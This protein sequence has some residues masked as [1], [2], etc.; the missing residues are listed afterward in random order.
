MSDHPAAGP[1]VR[2]TVI[3]PGWSAAV[4]KSMLG[5]R[6]FRSPWIW[7]AILVVGFWVA[8]VV[9]D[10]TP[11]ALVAPVVAAA[12]VVV[13]WWLMRRSVRRSIDRQLPVGSPLR[14]EYDY[15]SFTLHTPNG[16]S[17]RPYTAIRGVRVDGPVAFFRSAASNQTSAVP[18]E[19]VPDEVVRWYTDRSR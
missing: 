17:V 19:L 3:A 11:G 2:E 12:V 18:T 10:G 4:A 6:M 14:A 5:T 15:E 7:I 8:F 1:V 16:T 9:V 13:L